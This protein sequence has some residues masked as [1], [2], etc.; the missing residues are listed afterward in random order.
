LRSRHVEIVRNVAVAIVCVFCGAVADH[1]HPK[2]FRYT[3]RTHSPYSAM[4]KAVEE[5]TGISQS[6]SVKVASEML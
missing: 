5:K 1:N 3:G 6:D 2:F 4:T